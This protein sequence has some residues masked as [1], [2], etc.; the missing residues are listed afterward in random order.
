MKVHNNEN[1]GLSR[2]SAIQLFM[3]Y[4]LLSFI[5]FTARAAESSLLS[6]DER[7]VARVPQSLLIVSS[8]QTPAEDIAQNESQNADI[9]AAEAVRHR[10][11][12]DL[13][14]IPDVVGVA[15]DLADSQIAFN[16]EVDKKENV[17]EV[18][19]SV[20]TKIEGYDVEV[21]P[22]PTGVVAY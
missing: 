7:T 17:A 21:G 4:T 5:L 11:L 13:M 9:Q 1:T 19:R 6:R 8:C 2:A 18:E 15:I 22:A 10:H 14:K 16:V 20:P 3:S 12:A